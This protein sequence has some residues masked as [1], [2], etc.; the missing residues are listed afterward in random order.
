MY[1][2]ELTGTFFIDFCKFFHESLK[3]NRIYNYSKK[4]V[5]PP[6]LLNVNKNPTTTLILSNKIKKLILK[7]LK[8]EVKVLNIEIAVSDRSCNIN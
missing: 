5:G 3:D 4:R 1:W 2:H 6:Q 8:E 7:R